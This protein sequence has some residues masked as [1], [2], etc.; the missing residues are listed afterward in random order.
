MPSG[1]FRQ[2]VGRCLF[3]AGGGLLALLVLEGALRL[4][5]PPSVF[6]PLIPL[7][8]HQR[9]TLETAGMRGVAPEGTCSTNKWGLRG[10]EPP[11]AWHDYDTILTIGGS[12]THCFYLDDHKTWPY[13]LQGILRTRNP[14]T[15]VGNGGLDGHSTR[16]HILFMR[17]VVPRVK[18]NAVILLIG[19]NDLG[20]SLDPGRREQ[21]NPFESVS[22]A[23][24]MFTSSRLLQVLYNTKQ[25]VWNHAPIVHSNHARA[26]ASDTHYQ[27]LSGPEVLPSD[28]K[29][30]LPALDEYRS[31][32]RTI[33]SE[34]KRLGVRVVFLTQPIMVD[35]A[36]RWRHVSIAPWW[37]GTWP[38]E[39]SAATLFRLLEIYNATLLQTCAAEKAECFDLASAI[40]HREEYFYDTVHFTE[41]GA[42]LVA[43]QVGGYMLSGSRTD[44]R[45]S[46]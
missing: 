45:A 24:T 14:R 6:S 18:P 40:P 4:I 12:T 38:R 20:Y 15:W 16:G 2:T 46:H 11:A 36:E 23:Y 7:R 21:G 8:P 30:M 26:A 34:G 33:L 19:V 31:N 43:E 9:F 1:R 37:G 3:A 28:L 13:L 27:A 25:V 35:D 10:D 42:K 29:E 39:I 44:Q 22:L 32:I 5:A 17:E 41:A